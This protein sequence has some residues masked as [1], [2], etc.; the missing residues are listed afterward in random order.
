MCMCI[1]TDIYAYIWAYNTFFKI[2]ALMPSAVE[3]TCL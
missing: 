1:Y 3:E 2:K